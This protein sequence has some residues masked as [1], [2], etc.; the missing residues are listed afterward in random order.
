MYKRQILSRRGPV[1]K[2]EGNF[3][4]GIGLPLTLLRMTPQDQVVVL[5]MGISQPGEMK[6]LCDIAK[7]TVGLITNIGPAHLE[8]LGDMAGVAME[9]QVLFESIPVD[10]AVII[11]QDDPY[12]ATW[13]GEVRE[14]WTYA[15]EKDADL[16]ATE[17]TQD[18]VG[19]VFTLQLNRHNEGGGGKQKIILS[20]LGAHQVYNAMAASAA[21]LALCCQFDD[22][23][24]GLR[25]M[26]PVSLRGEVI[27]AGGATIFLDA[28]NANPESIKS[29]LQTLAFS[30]GGS[31]GHRMADT[32]AAPVGRRK[33]AIL[34]DMLELGEATKKSHID[35][36]RM[37][38]QYGIDRLIAV[39]KWSAFV[40]QGAR[41]KGM[42]K[43]AISTYKNL[44]EIN[45]RHEI[46]QGDIVL[47]K[48][49]RG[50]GMERALDPF[51][52]NAGADAV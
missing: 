17:I 28:Y 45:L 34:G 48:G 44:Q 41:E 25:N 37:V 3:N 26:R 43:E 2:T 22:I 40:A 20:L 42:P 32:L 29:A 52:K 7:P 4:N 5:E 10:G 14:T 21:A 1:L 12:L 33:I 9:K 18:S 24:D 36:G 38:V 39:G 8:F 23:R 35:I 31:I 30:F 27:E 50:M 51:R 6:R 49:S 19:T 47:V 11:N 46:Q 13:T 15:V 16:T